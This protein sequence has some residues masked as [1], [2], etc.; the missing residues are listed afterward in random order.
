MYKE[1]RHLFL[2]FVVFWTAVVTSGVVKWFN[3]VNSTKNVATTEKIVNENDSI[4]D[5]GVKE[6]TIK[7]IGVSEVGKE[8]IKNFESLSLKPYRIKGPR[9]SIGYG[10]L[11]KSKD[12]SWIKKKIA[13][14]KIST[15]DA[16]LIFKY[17]IEEIVNPA[18]R[19]MFKDLEKN[20][21]DTNEISQ[22]FIDGLGSLIY[23]C[24]E[25]GV[26]KTEFYRLLKR[27]KFNQAIAMVEKTHVYLRGHHVRRL[28]EAELMKS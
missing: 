5:D 13:N 25:D 26:R 11:I 23:N 8:H 24:G 4:E 18:I 22:G 2:L 19:R 15:A 10:H 20:G 17:D 21:V 12:P 14:N 9:Q 6:D 28:A 1:N 16:E 3:Y 7:E 27:N